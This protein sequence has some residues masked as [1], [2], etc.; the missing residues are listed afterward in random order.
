MEA[1]MTK[2]NNYIVKCT[3]VITETR[4]YIVQATD[5]KKAV[6]I[7]LAVAD[8]DKAEMSASALWYATEE[9]LY[10]CHAS[11]IGETTPEDAKLHLGEYYQ[12]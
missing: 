9:N 2:I 8:Q 1:L 3:A 5:E 6:D 7:V 11:V 10:H 12:Q 4:E